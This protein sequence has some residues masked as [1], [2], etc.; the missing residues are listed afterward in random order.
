MSGTEAPRPHHL[1]T[2]LIVSS[3][4]MSTFTLRFNESR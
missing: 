1:S 2:S 4:I 3:S